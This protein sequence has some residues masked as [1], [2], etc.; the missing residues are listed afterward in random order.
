VRSASFGPFR[1]GHRTVSKSY[2]TV[3]FSAVRVEGNL[4]RLQLRDARPVLLI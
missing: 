4:I 3:S 1:A 2:Q